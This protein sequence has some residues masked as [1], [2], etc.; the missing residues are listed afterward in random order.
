MNRVERE[1]FIKASMV[2]AHRCFV[3][4]AI[5][6]TSSSRRLSRAS[7]INERYIVKPEMTSIHVNEEML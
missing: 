1:V 4:T 7:A 6:C 5:L 3:F 2:D